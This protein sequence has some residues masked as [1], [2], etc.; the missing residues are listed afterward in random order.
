LAAQ[1]KHNGVEPQVGVEKDN[2]DKGANMEFQEC[3]ATII[4]NNN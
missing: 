4:T 2:H 3:N 1:K